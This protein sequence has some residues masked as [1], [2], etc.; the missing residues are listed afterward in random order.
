MNSASRAR[1]L[2][3]E[4]EGIIA[5]DLQV[6]LGKLGYQVPGI[7]S[8]GEGAI[9]MA[10]DLQP[11]LV[12]MDIVLW[13][14]MDGV[15]AAAH[16]RER[17]HIPVI[18]LTA[19]SD[20]ATLQRAKV[21]GPHGY[22]VKPLVERELRIGIEMALHKHAMECRLAEQQRWY[23]TTLTCIGEAVIA[24]DHDGGVRFMNSLAESITGLSQTQ[25]LGR[26]LD[27]V[28]ILDTEVSP[29]GSR[30]PYAE[31]IRKGLVIEWSGNTALRPRLGPSTPIDYTATRIR[32]ADGTVAG[33]VV[34]FRDV[35]PRRQMEEDR[36]RLIRELQESLANVKTL[37]GL[38]PICA[39][40]KKIREDRDYWVQ[41]E[42]YMVAHAD[43]KFTHTLCPSCLRSLYPEFAEEILADEKREAGGDGPE[44]WPSRK[45]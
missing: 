10:T 21:T 42:A 18:F 44:P 16:I 8:T 9:E 1:I 25:A 28:M 37:T 24:T 41:V 30:G 33:V 22:L 36:E 13:G 12:L 31:A 32:E 20:T 6:T 43:A 11:N 23:S 39:Q 38:I 26:P 40:C 34:V 3:V 14:G 29:G 7:A 2:I 15:E 19:H 35:T 5:Q 4:D 17:L 27:H 45:P